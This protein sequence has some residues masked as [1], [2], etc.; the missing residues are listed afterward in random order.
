MANIA[1]RV[2]VP[3]VL[4]TGA[5]TLVNS[6]GRFRKPQYQPFNSGANVAIPRV[7]LP[8][9][10]TPSNPSPF[11]GATGVGGGFSTDVGL[12]WAASADAT[13][14]DVYFGTTNPPPLVSIQQGTTV[15]A[16]PSNLAYSTTY[17]WKIRAYNFDAEA[18]GPV[19]SFATTPPT[20][21]AKPSVPSPVNAGVNYP[22]ETV[23]SWAATPG[24]LTYD[25]YFGLDPASLSLVSTAQVG[26][27]YDPPGNLNYLTAYY[28]KIVAN[29]AIGS[30]SGDVWGFQTVMEPPPPTA[31]PLAVLVNGSTY[32]GIKRGTINIRDVQSFDSP[33][34]CSFKV[35]GTRYSPPAEGSSIRIK[36]G[37]TTLF[38]GTVTDTTQSYTELKENVDWDVSCQGP[39]WLLNRREPFA[40][41]ISVSASDAARSLISDFSTGF[42]TAGIEDN[43]PNISLTFTGEKPLSACLAE[44]KKSIGATGFVDYEHDIK[45]YITEPAEALPPDPIDVNNKLLLVVPSSIS[46][47]RDISQLRNRVYAKGYGESTTSEVA[48][49][50]TIVPIVDASRFNPIGG[51]A[52]S[53]YLRFNYSGTQ[54]GALGTG[55][56]GG[57][58]GTASKPESLVSLSLAAGAGLSPGR[59]GYAYT[60]V[61]ASGES[62]PGPT[63]WIDVG[64]AANPPTFAPVASLWAPGFGLFLDASADYKWCYTYKHGA[65]GQ[66][67][68]PSPVSNQLTT[69]ALFGSPQNRAARIDRAHGIKTGIPAGFGLQF[70]R[71]KGN[72]VAVFWNMTG[73]SDGFY[74]DSA[75]WYNDIYQ[76]DDGG[77]SPLI[78]GTSHPPAGGTT[79]GVAQVQL[80]NVAPG[81]TG[82]TGRNIY[83][84]DAGGS[85]LKKLTTLSNNTTTS[86][87]DASATVTGS[88]VPTVNTAGFVEQ[89]G[90][91]VP[92][93]TTLPVTFIDRYSAT[94]GW[95]AVGSLL[96]RYTGVSGYNLTGIPASGIGSVSSPIS[97]GSIADPQPALTG[98]TGLTIALP[99]NSPVNI[100]IQKDDLTAQA[101]LGNLE[102]T[103]A[104][105]A[106][107]GIHEFTITDER[108]RDD[109]AEQWAETDLSIF[110]MPI[111][112]IKYPTMDVKSGA[113]KT[114]PV[115]LPAPQSYSGS[116]KIQEVNISEIDIADGKWPVFDVTASSVWF[117][118][119]DLV[120]RARLL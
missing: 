95:I 96:I 52:I 99:V 97:F 31:P 41:F 107:D 13:Y 56:T 90:S 100:W 44:I 36:I 72:D 19:W 10:T 62:T 92:G 29:N 73:D 93:V 68:G 112:T 98:V 21:P 47:T 3:V 110:A 91:I 16:Y 8:T 4:R 40:E 17:Y 116:M 120:R 81:P 77:S 70:Y 78:L 61:T 76:A 103:E 57:K 43:L 28:W 89:T 88:N 63:V 27:T 20:P 69:S 2:L 119:E 66:E 80:N 111:V 9:P 83:R 114:I 54:L 46:H 102:R 49:G 35:D 5:T 67:T 37:T 42:T 104:N 14:Y 105:V 94:G 18:F 108:I 106:T 45:L 12:S 24:A 60:W 75:D 71:S 30:T 74:S 87:L 1:N 33:N 55:L 64:T 51:K 48:I 109:T 22:R 39:T 79:V 23:L 65:S 25:V 115:D 53:R 38:R 118:F 82:T 113:G 26:H 15:W 85:Q 7:A 58:I 117:S 59:Y 11:N 101:Y 84:T 50:E 86:Y 34:T 6:A 32:V